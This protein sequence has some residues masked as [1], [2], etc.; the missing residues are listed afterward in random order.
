MVKWVA[1]VLLI[2]MVL[3]QL[4]PVPPC[5]LDETFDTREACETTVQPPESQPRIWYNDD[6]GDPQFA[7]IRASIPDAP[8]HHRV[9]DHQV[10]SI[11]FLPLTSLAGRTPEQLP[12]GYRVYD[13]GAP[14]G[15]LAATS[16]PLLI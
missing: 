11:S 5:L 10:N 2:G 13:S 3:V 9:T 8:V 7:E 12:A 1:N 15:K 4:G 6:V 14:P 16:L